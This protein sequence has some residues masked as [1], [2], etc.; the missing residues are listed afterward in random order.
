MERYKSI[1]FPDFTPLTLTEFYF[2]LVLN[3]EDTNSWAVRKRVME[4]TDNQV[5]IVIPTLYYTA[6]QLKAK[7][8]IKRSERREHGRGN[9][10]AITPAGKNNLG[11]EIKRLSQAVTFYLQKPQ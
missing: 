2:L 4:I 7:K 10:Y 3:R 6:N 11:L 1:E 5:S 9:I 8:L